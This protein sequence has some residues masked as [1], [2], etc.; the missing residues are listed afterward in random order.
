VDPVV[1]Y[2]CRGVLALVFL[3]A[4]AHKLRAPREFLATLR[5][6]GIVPAGLAPAVAVLL[7]GTEAGVGAGLLAPATHGAAA[8]AATL[9]LVVYG[10]SIAFN[11]LRGRRDIDCG[12]TGPAARQPLSAWLVLRN[13]CLA[14]LGIAALLPGS[15]RPLG[16]LDGFTIAAAVAVLYVQYLASNLLLAYQPRTQALA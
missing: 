4:A 14:A 10:A 11:L 8:L 16:A 15:G 1:G 6:Y 7:V 5:G 9:L 12:C 2:V 13:V 3:S